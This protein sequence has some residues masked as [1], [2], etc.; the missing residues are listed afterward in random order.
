V[1]VDHGTTVAESVMPSVRVPRPIGATRSPCPDSRYDP[2]AARVLLIR[3]LILATLLPFAAAAQPRPGV[4]AKDV[5][6]CPATHPIKGNFTTYS[7]ERC[8]FHMRG[9]QF[10]REDE[11]RAVLCDRR[12]GSPGRLPTLEAIGRDCSASTGKGDRRGGA[13]LWLDIATAFARGG[14]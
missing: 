9:G 6:T 5:W 14:G 13:L 10:V 8:I 7:G 4:E 12:R 11:A 3:A 1:T 2:R